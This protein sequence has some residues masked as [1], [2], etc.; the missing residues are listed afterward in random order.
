MTLE[1]CSNLDNSVIL[2]HSK[3][4]LQGNALGFDNDSG[5]PSAAGKASLSTEANLLSFH[6][7]KSWLFYFHHNEIF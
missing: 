1:V 5:F 4:H 7:G 2:L 6:L 3:L